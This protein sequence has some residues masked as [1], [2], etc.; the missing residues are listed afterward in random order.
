[1]LRAARG[2]SERFGFEVTEMNVQA[3]QVHLL[4]MVPPEVP[5][6]DFLGTIKGLTAIRVLNKYKI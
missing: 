4:F 2:F 5:A 6:P 1:M 3:D